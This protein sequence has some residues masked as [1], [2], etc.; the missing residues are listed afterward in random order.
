LGTSKESLSW[1]DGIIEWK[2][3]YPKETITKKVIP[4]TGKIV[5]LKT[6]DEKI[7]ND[8]MGLMFKFLKKNFN[9][10]ELIFKFLKKNFNGK[11]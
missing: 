1:K 9:G 5:K 2:D 11:I 8:G 3:Y 4:S 6:R 10:M 7:A